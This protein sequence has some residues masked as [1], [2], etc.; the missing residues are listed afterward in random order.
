MTESLS[1]LLTG[2]KCK[3]TSV[4]K[5]KLNQN[6]GRKTQQEKTKTQ[7]ERKTEQERGKHS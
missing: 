6:L 5:K 3:A 2:V 7:V 1:H 4:A